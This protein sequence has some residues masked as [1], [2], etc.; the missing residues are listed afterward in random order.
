MCLLHPY[1]R[2]R[3]AGPLIGAPF[4]PGDDAPR[5]V[6]KNYFDQICP[7]SKRVYIDAEEVNDDKIRYGENI[8]ASYMFD[9]WVKKLNSIEEQCVEILQD[10]FQLFEIW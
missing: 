7:K 10:S 4:E 1:L 2:P 9:R 3:I 8:G 5:A 6:S